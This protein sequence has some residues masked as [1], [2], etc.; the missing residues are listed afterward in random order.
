MTHVGPVPR[1]QLPVVF[2]ASQGH[3]SMI[4]PVVQPVLQLDIMPTL[5]QTLVQVLINFACFSLLYF[6]YLLECDSTC[7]TCSGGS[8]SSCSSCTGSLYLLSATNTCGT[9]CLNGYWADNSTNT[10]N[11]CNATCATCPDSVNCTA[12]TSD[13]A[14]LYKRTC[15]QNYCPTR[16]YK[17]V[18]TMMC[19][20]CPTGCKTCSS[21][22]WCKT[23]ASGYSRYLDSTIQNQS[24]IQNCPTGYFSEYSSLDG[25]YECQACDSSCAAC[26]GSSSSQCT[27]CPGDEILSRGSCFSSSFSCP[28]GTYLDSLQC[29]AC[30]KGCALCSEISYC[31][32]C[33]SGYTLGTTTGLC[34]LSQSSCDSSCNTCSGSTEYDCT[35]CTSPL[36]FQTGTCL[37][38]C[39][40]GFTYNVMS[41]QCEICFTGCISCIPSLIYYGENCVFSCPAG[42]ITVIDET[43]QV[44][45][46]L[47]GVIPLIA[48]VQQPSSTAVIALNQDLNIQVTV[49]YPSNS[50]SSSQTYSIN[51]VQTDINAPVTQL[52]QGISSLNTAVLVIPKQ[53]LI[54][55]T[56]YELTIQALINGN[57]AT[58]SSISF[59]T[60]RAIV[61]GNFDVTPNTG[62]FYSTTFAL[63]I[64]GW[65][66]NTANGVSMSFTI[67][68]SR[69]DNPTKQLVIVSSLN[70]LNA[71]TSSY[72]F[73]I[74]SLFEASS[75]QSVVYNIELRANS[76]SDS[77][78]FSKTIT[79][80][81]LSTEQAAEL[82]ANIDPTTL[83]EPTAITNFVILAT[84]NLV[85]N[86]SLETQT[87]TAMLA[88][89]QTYVTLTGDS[90]VTCVD[91]IHCSGHGTCIATTGTT[92]STNSLCTCDSGWG[93]HSCNK[94]A[95]QLQQTQ[96]NVEVA[97]TNLLGTSPT[98]SSVGSQLSAIQSVSADS[99]L[100]ANGSAVPSLMSNTVISSSSILSS[101]SPRA[102]LSSLLA[103]AFSL[104]F[105]F[106]D[107]LGDSST[108]D[109][110][111]Q[112][113]TNSLQDLLSGLGTGDEN[114]IDSA[115]LYLFAQAVDDLFTD[116][117]DDSDG[118]ES[119]S[120]S[121]ESRR[122]LQQTL[123]E[124]QPYYRQPRIIS[125]TS[126]TITPN[127][128][129]TAALK[130]QA[131][132][133]SPFTSSPTVDTSKLVQVLKSLL[134]TLLSGR[135]IKMKA[136]T[137]Y[138]TISGAFKIPKLTLKVS[139]SVK[140]AVQETK[141]GKNN[142]ASNSNSL[143][144]KSV[145]FSANDGQKAIPLT[146][147]GKPIEMFI[148][149]TTPTPVSSRGS[150]T[151]QCS[152][153]DETSK[154]FLANGC[155][156]VGENLTH[157]FC[158]C[159]HATEFA[160]MINEKTLNS[161]DNLFKPSLSEL[162][163]LSAKKSSQNPAFSIS[164]QK[165]ILSKITIAIMQYKL[166]KFKYWPVGVSLIILVALLLLYP[167]IRCLQVVK[168]DYLTGWS[169]E[170]QDMSQKPNSQKFDPILSC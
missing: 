51:W 160:A 14:F 96:Q 87:T 98:V 83:T 126:S 52:L 164:L 153:Y 76:S 124:Q 91:A 159:N 3:S 104:P 61:G 39:S 165:N 118:S 100:V 16:T 110:L 116:S 166:T 35:S 77:L 167:F 146:N 131:S 63:G 170:L 114:E 149:K 44:S 23:C 88:A 8:S 19:Y 38:S 132:T 162:L 139:S 97:M 79:L 69:S 7:Y 33:Q 80:Q 49:T 42:T 9:S 143:V 133:Q 4:K 150:S 53:N 103:A 157:I 134:N 151:Y 50:S 25:T 137:N 109:Q 11:A 102:L 125:S 117:T 119:E 34:E 12:C 92:D 37:R 17:N 66:A 152:Y 121:G 28:D 68:A 15:Y 108:L 1:I 43:G 105:Q 95:Q 27:D 82:I 169:D 148:P 45:C 62:S 47:E 81:T 58:A 90:S 20:D 18:T 130:N 36:V 93:G 26:N 163:T 111:N 142:Q 113:F 86:S 24:C 168:R 64:S 67:I 101:S 144:T 46:F 122:V 70:L 29:L 138:N 129:K 158:Q 107:V 57:P 155:K 48:F 2:N 78:T 147:L 32:T 41:F 120:E 85:Q 136:P 99:D 145:T 73:T 55:N 112:V 135:T 156:F 154:R 40:P 21:S 65:D 71:A 127:D 30:S 13:T 5:L 128:K 89:F 123:S 74:P 161:G 22:D 72:S 106:S 54:S 141:T 31:V 10:C 94:D 6:I 56:Y 59:T 60:D 75:E 84:Q 140:F 115:S